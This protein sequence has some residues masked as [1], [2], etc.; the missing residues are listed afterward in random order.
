MKKGG[1]MHFACGL[2]AAPQELV[3]YGVF[4]GL[5]R[6][7]VVPATGELAVQ[8]YARCTDSIT[9][10]KIALVEPPITA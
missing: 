10:L 9:H 3:F 4:D 7:V 2:I 6:E 1:N 8:R 5:A